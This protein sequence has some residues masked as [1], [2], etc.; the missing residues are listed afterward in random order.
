ML[1]YQPEEMMGKSLFDFYHAADGFE[2][3]KSFKSCKIV[4]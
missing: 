3:A 4:V 1:G 2:L